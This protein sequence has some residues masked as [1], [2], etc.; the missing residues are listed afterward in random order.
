MLDL[1]NVYNLPLKERVVYL[2][3]YM[4]KYLNETQD[5]DISIFNLDLIVS[6]QELTFKSLSQIYFNV[7]IT[8]EHIRIH[9][10]KDNRIFRFTELTQG[11]G[12]YCKFSPALNI[13]NDSIYFEED[14]NQDNDMNAILNSIYSDEI[15]HGLENISFNFTLD[16]YKD[17]ILKH[18]PDV[19]IGV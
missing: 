5:K 3:L 11:P 16:L 6:N 4:I 14:T 2:I 15:F 8:N 17:I 12:H 10:S 18:Y 7:E 13:P 19:R 1:S 9:N